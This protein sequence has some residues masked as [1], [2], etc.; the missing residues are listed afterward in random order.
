[1]SSKQPCKL[2]YG[3]QV[4]VCNIV[5]CRIGIIADVE[6]LEAELPVLQ[7]AIITNYLCLW[8]VFSE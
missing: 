6:L 1:M 4:A 2:S 8:Q 7:G 5:F 3:F